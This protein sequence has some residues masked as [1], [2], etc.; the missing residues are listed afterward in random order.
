[1]KSLKT[2]SYL[3]VNKNTFATFST[4]GPSSFSSYPLHSLHLTCTSP[5]QLLVFKKVRC[6]VLPSRKHSCCYGR[7]RKSTVEEGQFKLS[8]PNDAII[9][10]KAMDFSLEIRKVHAY[11]FPF[12]LISAN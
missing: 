11:I 6:Y 4:D 2:H 9:S 10:K 8:L 3:I 7:L 1:M 12:Q 5:R